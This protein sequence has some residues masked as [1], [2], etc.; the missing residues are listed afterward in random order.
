MLHLEFLSFMLSLKTIL[1]SVAPDPVMNMVAQFIPSNATSG[2]YTIIWT[3][4]PTTNG[5]FYQIL[6]YSYSSA[7]TVGP[8]YDGTFTGQ[9]N[10]SQNQYT[11]DALY[12]TNY[13]FTI[14]TY[15]M[16]YDITNGPIQIFN[17][18]SPASMDEIISN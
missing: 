15:N 6:E 10:Q 8:H 18:S 17:Q 16:K 9:L 3:L 5:S 12:F 11:F 14:T 13:N 2:I 1:V 4:P 7:Y